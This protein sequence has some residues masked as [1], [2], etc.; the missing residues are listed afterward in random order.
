MSNPKSN[1]EIQRDKQATLDAIA[2]PYSVPMD[3]PNKEVVL[4]SNMPTMVRIRFFNLRDPGRELKFFLKTATHPLHHYTLFHDK[5]YDLPLEVVQ[6]L[7]GMNPKMPNSCMM[8]I[9]KDKLADDGIQSQSYIS[10]WKSLFQCKFI[11]QL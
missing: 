1:S 8:P 9:R 10:S 5:E 7:E 2:N 6:H 3:L 4:Q 11:K